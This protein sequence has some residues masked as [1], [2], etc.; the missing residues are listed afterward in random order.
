MILNRKSPILA[1]ITAFSTAV[2]R[3]CGQ[4]D[5]SRVDGRKNSLSEAALCMSWVAAGIRAGGC[6]KRR[7]CCLGFEAVALIWT[8]RAQYWCHWDWEHLIEY[9]SITPL[10]YMASSM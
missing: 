4:S 8:F 5:A 10:V 6:G 3:T 7:F 2:C 1:G 9:S